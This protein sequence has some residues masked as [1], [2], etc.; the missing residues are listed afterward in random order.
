MYKVDDIPI[1]IPDNQV[2]KLL[3][4]NKEHQHTNR[5]LNIYNKEKEKARE[6]IQT[7]AIFIIE[8]IKNLPS[9]DI[10]TG[11]REVALCVLTIGPRL[12]EKVTKL[13][14]QLK[15]E[16]S[17]IL[18]AIGSVATEEAAGFLNEKINNEARIRNYDYTNRYSP[19]YC[20]WVLN[21]QRLIFNKVPVDE[22]NV[23]L[24]DSLMMLPRKSI[25][26][27]VNFGFKEELDLNLGIR[28]CDSCNKNNCKFNKNQI[29]R[30]KKS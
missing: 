28:T 7:K 13:A 4:Y 29:D 2:F 22:I 26:F 6:L 21:D 15:L 3:G 25:T 9:R 19:G 20:T 11:A 8:N 24:T 14:K 27:A 18:D 1:E 5:F 30:R 10:F 16:R 23:K 17:V 12:E